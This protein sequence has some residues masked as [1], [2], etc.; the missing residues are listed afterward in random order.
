MKRVTKL[1]TAMLGVLFLLSLG[2]VEK[3]EKK[4]PEPEYYFVHG[5]SAEV[6]VSDSINIEVQL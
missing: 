2:C 5:E 6:Y 1:F 4:I 3:N